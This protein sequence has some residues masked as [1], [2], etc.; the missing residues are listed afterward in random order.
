M[1]VLGRS[2]INNFLL[3]VR[4]GARD[5]AILIAVDCFSLLCIAIDC[6][7]VLLTALDCY[8]PPGG[9]PRDCVN[10]WGH[11][12]CIDFLCLRF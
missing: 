3:M 2:R 1:L 5:R 10:L 4:A 12:K 8:Q 11:A 9:N 6:Y 7:R